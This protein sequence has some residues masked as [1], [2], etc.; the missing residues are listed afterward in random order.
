MPSEKKAPASRRGHVRESRQRE[1]LNIPQILLLVVVT[2]ASTWFLAGGL[3]AGLA[4]LV[5]RFLGHVDPS[6]QFGWSDGVIKVVYIIG[7]IVL[8]L[9][10]VQLVIIT[11][12]QVIR[13]GRALSSEIEKRQEKQRERRIE[14]QW[15]VVSRDAQRDAAR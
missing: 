5:L 12:R 2:I 9:T 15:R 7:I 4:G 3:V 8:I 6:N 14:Q 11:S 10:F 13:A 1:A